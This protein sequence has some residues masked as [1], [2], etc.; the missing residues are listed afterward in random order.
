MEKVRKLPKYDWLESQ[1]YITPSTPRVFRQEPVTI[2]EREKLLMKNDRHFVVIRPKAYVDSSGNA[3]ANE[4]ERLRL[5]YPDDFKAIDLGN[6]YSKCVHSLCAAVHD[7]IFL[8]VDMSEEGDILKVTKDDNCKHRSYEMK[9]LQHLIRRGEISELE[10][11]INFHHCTEF[12]KTQGK[13]LFKIQKDLLATAMAIMS[14]KILEKVF[15]KI[16]STFFGKL[17]LSLSISLN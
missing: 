17:N 13:E 10:W 16:S 5:L 8:Y 6:S 1:M 4:T 3:W 15:G 14:Q 9:R 2:D 12:E 7:D 11:N